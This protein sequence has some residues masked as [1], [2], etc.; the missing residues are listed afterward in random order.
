MSQRSNYF[1][2]FVFIYIPIGEV[3]VFQFI[4]SRQPRSN[5]IP[6]ISVFFFF[7][8]FLQIGAMKSQ[9]QKR[10]RFLAANTCTHRGPTFSAKS[11]ETAQCGRVGALGTKKYKIKDG[12]P[13]A[14]QKAW[15]VFLSFFIYFARLVAMIGG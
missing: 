1:Q 8:F 5:F 3:H 11:K 14:M 7:F 13:K 6:F 4:S 12:A 2:P 9:K 15:L 10:Y